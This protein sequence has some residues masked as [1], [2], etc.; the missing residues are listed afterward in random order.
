MLATYSTVG[1]DDNNQILSYSNLNF[2]RLL[3]VVITPSVKIIVLYRS[4]S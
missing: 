2:I 4:I 1:I 3:R